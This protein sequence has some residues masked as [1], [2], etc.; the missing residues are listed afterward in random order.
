MSVVMEWVKTNVFI[1]I[2]AVLMIAALVTLPILSSSMN[3]G[4]SKTM[5]K[6]VGLVSDLRSLEK[7]NVEQP[8]A[9]TAVQSQPA[10]VNEDLLEAYRQLGTEMRTDADAVINKALAFNRKDHDVFMDRIFPS[11]PPE[12]SEVLPRRF[13]EALI[14]AY[15]ALFDEINAGQPP[16][17][18]VLANELRRAEINFISQS[19]QKESRGDL[20]EEETQELT[21]KLGKIRLG[22]NR[23][24]AQAIEIYLDQYEAL[25]HIP[26]WDQSQIPTEAYMFIW[27]W[28]YWITHEILM[29]L[30]HANEKNETVLLA[31]VKQLISMTINGMPTVTP[32]ATQTSRLGGGG[33]MGST[34]SREGASDS[35]SST[36]PDV[37]TSGGSI[38][39]SLP[40]PQDFAYRF[41][42]RNTN[43]L[44]DVFPVDLELIVDSTRIPE[45]LD[46]IAQENFF[47]ITNLVI[48]P[49]D[50]FVAASDG[51]MFGLAPVCHLELTVET[52]WLRQ[53][54]SEKMPDAVKKV[55]GMLDAQSASDDE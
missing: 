47:T 17:I 16:T 39:P 11:M 34:G 45:V 31:P 29:A 20:T 12:E 27:N 48:R 50:P 4:I 24:H 41:T 6:R 13:H 21:K 25:L 10:L 36:E 23:E 46:A 43:A 15:D 37:V 33:V 49:A 53:W 5:S 19:V 26:G 14:E 32:Y 42:G 55:L 52:V 7:T 1:V 8:Q 44:Y 51:Y 30:H 28:E 9:A 38:N 22:K 35:G 40:V 3:G 18:V 54:T 2:F